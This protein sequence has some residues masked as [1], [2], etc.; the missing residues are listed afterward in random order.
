MGNTTSTDENTFDI[1]DKHAMEETIQTTQPSEVPKNDDDMNG[2]IYIVMHDNIPIF[3]IRT[4]RLEVV[5]KKMDEYAKKIIAHS[6]MKLN[7]YS[8]YMEKY[9]YG[10]RLMSSQNIFLMNYDTLHSNIRC[11]KVFEN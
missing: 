1:I 7:D 10:I 9:Q 11:V 3:Y 8:L 4:D 2:P 5:S 6:M